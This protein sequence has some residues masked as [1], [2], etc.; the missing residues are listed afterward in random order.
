MSFK[1]FLEYFENEINYLVESGKELKKIYPMMSNLDFSNESNDPDMK[2]LIEGTA[3]LNANLQKRIDEKNI[4]L[5]QEILNSL[6]PYFN[7]PTPSISVF[8]I[9]EY[10][11]MLTLP[12]YSKI[13][14]KINYDGSPYTFLTS[15]EITTSSF[16]ISDIKKISSDVLPKKIAKLTDT[17]IEIS[18]NSIFNVQEDEIIL[19]INQMESA[20]TK[21]YEALFTFYPQKNTPVFENEEKIGE[22]EFMDD[23]SILPTLRNEN[24]VYQSV[25]DFNLFKEKFFFV[26]IKLSKSPQNS[27]HIPIKNNNAL[28]INKNTFLLN[29]VVGVNIFEKTSEPLFINQKQI[30]YPLYLKP[31][32][33]IYSIYKI[34]NLAQPSQNFINYFSLDISKKKENDITWYYKKDTNINST[35]FLYFFDESFEPKTIYVKYLC[36]QTNA[37]DLISEGDQWSV[38]NYNLKCINIKKPTKYFSNSNYNDSQRKLIESLN[39][40]YYGL[41]EEESLERIKAL[42]DIYSNYN[43]PLHYLNPIKNIEFHTQMAPYNGTMIPKITAKITF[44]PDSKSFIMCRV[45]SKLL[46]NTIAINKKLTIELINND[47]NETWK[48]WEIK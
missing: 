40:N 44:E 13:N 39:L 33:D 24:Q 28:I 29:C 3:F 14:S 47:T 45:I 27:L 37:N 30:R 46:L 23:F 34:Q 9:H 18:L 20:A 21:L 38:E 12:K 35:T 41:N 36:I 5:S 16:Q 11:R 1:S 25:I 2:R 10:K 19:Y 31:N 32:T 42:F 26:K 22:I 48:E 4:E 6:Y 15:H 43:S 17:A 7:R 8:Q